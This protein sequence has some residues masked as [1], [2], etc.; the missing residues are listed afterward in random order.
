MVK[1]FHQFIPALILPVPEDCGEFIPADP[2]NGAV[3]EDLADDGTGALQV[4]VA[5]VMTVIVVDHL[6]VIA[7]KEAYGKRRKILSLPC[8]LL[9]VLQEEVER[10]QVAHRRQRISVRQVVQVADITFQVRNQLVER[11]GQ[12]TDLV[13]G[14][15]LQRN[16]IITGVHFPGCLRQ[17]P[18]RP[19]QVTGKKRGGQDHKNQQYSQNNHNLL[20]PPEPVLIDFRY[21]YSHVQAHTV[22]QRQPG[23]L[24]RHSVEGVVNNGAFIQHTI[25]RF[26]FIFAFQFL[27]G[28]LRMVNDNSF[29]IIDES[30]TAGVG[31]D[32]VHQS[33]HGRIINLN[34]D[35]AH[36][37][38]LPVDRHVI[39]K[40]KHIQVVCHIGRQPDS[41]SGGLRHGK[42]HQG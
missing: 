2:E 37:G 21:G 12:D 10:A 32:I 22:A 30:I 41:L 18:E 9:Q 28:H 29:R 11:A 34:T 20:N 14:P 25:G 27:L 39:G 3:G 1:L 33:R 4:K 16:V 23:R 24:L 42:P 13:I 35:H 31:P 7:V 15:V 19:G 6:Q 36:K 40:H 26:L 5:L 8:V 38:A 17:L